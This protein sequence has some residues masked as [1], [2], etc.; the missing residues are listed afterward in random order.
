MWEAKG[1][2]SSCGDG[3]LGRRKVPSLLAQVGA[4]FLR[5]GWP[6]PGQR[7][8]RSRPWSVRTCVRS[9]PARSPR[10]RFGR[11]CSGLWCS[12]AIL[13]FVQVCGGLWVVVQ[14]CVAFGLLLVGVGCSLVVVATEVRA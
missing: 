4:M 13:G 11:S 10:G 3:E 12:W 7:L 9:H 6:F 2:G 14:V 1:L 5:G 8:E